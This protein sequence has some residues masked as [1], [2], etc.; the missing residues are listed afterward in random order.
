VEGEGPARWDAG[1]QARY[2][3]WP[4]V[5]ARWGATGKTGTPA[6][7]CRCKRRWEQ[8]WFGGAAGRTRSSPRLP[9]MAPRA[10]RSWPG[11]HV[12]GTRGA[13]RSVFN[14]EEVGTCSRVKD[15]RLNSRYGATSI[16]ALAPGS[17]ARTAGSCAA[18]PARGG[19][20][21]GFWAVSGF[22]FQD[23]NREN[24]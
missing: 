5:S 22:Q 16:L 10:A 11:R 19:G 3:P 8:A 17:T 7:L 2:P 15:A 20:E 24:N 18:R 21:L 4:A 9:A 6:S 14:E 12:G 13:T 1:G 23:V